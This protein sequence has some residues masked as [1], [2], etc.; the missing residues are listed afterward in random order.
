MPL[1]PEATRPELKD[2]VNALESRQDVLEARLAAIEGDPDDR[3]KTRPLRHPTPFSGPVRYSDPDAN[4]VCWREPERTSG[5]DPETGLFA[6][7][8]DL[9]M[10]YAGAV[11]AEDND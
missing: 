10:K 7:K 8:R 1:R 3:A 2:F 5:I 11:S 9:D 6:L 4:G